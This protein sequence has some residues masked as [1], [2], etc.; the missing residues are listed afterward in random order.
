VF[1]APLSRSISLS[2][3]PGQR[4]VGRLGGSK[5]KTRFLGANETSPSVQAAGELAVDPGSKWNVVTNVLRHWFR[6]SHD[7][8]PSIRFAWHK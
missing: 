4:D 8:S 3:I 2:L 5:G 7:V 1:S 6:K